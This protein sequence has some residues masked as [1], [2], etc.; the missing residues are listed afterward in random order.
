MAILL[1]NKLCTTFEEL[2]FQTLLI[3]VTIANTIV[4]LTILKKNSISFLI[5]LFL[6]CENNSAEYEV[7]LER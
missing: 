1:P 6:L 5:S 7:R 2:I 4:L 3:L